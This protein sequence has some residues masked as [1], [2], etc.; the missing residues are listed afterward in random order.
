MTYLR[1]LN[2]TD[3]YRHVGPVCI[4]ADWAAGPL[5]RRDICSQPGP[6]PPRVPDCFWRRRHPVLSSSSAPSSSS[7]ARAF[8]PPFSARLHPPM[9]LLRL[10]AA[11]RANTA[12]I[13]VI[14]GVPLALATALLYVRIASEEVHAQ[15][16]FIAAS[17]SMRWQ[18]SS[19]CSAN[20]STTCTSPMLPRHS[21][22]NP[23]SAM[24]TLQTGVRVR[25]EGLGITAKSLATFAILFPDHRRGSST[26][27][28]VAFAGGQLALQPRRVRHVRRVTRPGP[29]AAS[30]PALV[31]R[32]IVCMSVIFS[33][34]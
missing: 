3:S 12:F 6:R 19:S 8:A 32:P 5:A 13:P 34:L 14:V 23:R 30:N 18:P 9:Q 22:T 33:W 4:V 24:T 16:H 2:R 26:L 1:A 25:A 7:A 27:A 11:R 29:Y 17:P 10:A 21:G 28:L 20:L 31:R 15:P